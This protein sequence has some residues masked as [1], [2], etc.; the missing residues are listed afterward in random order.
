LA[1]IPQLLGH[2]IFNWSLKFIPVS[3]VSLTLLGEPVGSTILA[4][5]I[6]Q[7]SPG[8]VKIAGAVFILAGIWL[9][10]KSG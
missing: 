4:Y 6:L 1:L 8:L 5:F 7:E 3:L 9:A 2:S 10:A